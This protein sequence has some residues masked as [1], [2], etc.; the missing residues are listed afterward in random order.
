MQLLIC[1]K[2]PLPAPPCLCV[3][4]FMSVYKCA[5]QTRPT[6]SQGL[7]VPWALIAFKHIYG[8]RG[9]ANF[10]CATS[11]KQVQWCL[12]WLESDAREPLVS[13]WVIHRR[14]VRWCFFGSIKHD[15]NWD[16]WASSLPV[17]LYWGECDAEQEPCC[18]F[19]TDMTS[20]GYHFQA[21]SR[22]WPSKSR[23]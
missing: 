7:C 1:N 22:L 20:T 5:F 18:S 16:K 9:C 4:V 17:Q 6:F 13:K 12:D 19:I 10:L 14:R 21:A 23:V 15:R 8:T 3:C 2:Y 11:W